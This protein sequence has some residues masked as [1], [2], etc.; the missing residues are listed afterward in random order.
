MSQPNRKRRRA[1]LGMLLLGGLLAVSPAGLAVAE[2]ADVPVEPRAQPPYPEWMN[3]LIGTLRQRDPDAILMGDSLV[4]AWP[5]DL[6]GSLFEGEVVNFGAGGDK[7]NNLLWRVRNAFGPGMRLSSAL[8][9]VGTNDL[10]KRSAEGIAA[11][12]GQI[13][14]EVQAAAPKACVTVVALLPRRDGGVAFSTKI[15]EVNERLFRLVSPRVRV[16]DPSA[17][18]LERCPATSSCDLYKDPVHLTR[19]G[20]EV[21]TS[22][23]RTAQQQHPCP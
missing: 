22:F 1:W 13:L 16:V 18:L 2:S 19:A 14:S 6:S 10:P 11:S 8:I 20:Y 3:R 9:L 4:A 12:I 21:L 15:R 5:K 23:V 7:T 17:P